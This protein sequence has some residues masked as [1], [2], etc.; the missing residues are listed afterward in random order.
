MAEPAI[1]TVPLV[2]KSSPPNNCSNVVLP[3]PDAPTIAIRSPARTVIEAPRNT[4]SRTPPWMKS[5]ARSTPSSTTLLE[6]GM[7]NGMLLVIS[8]RFRRQQARSSPGGI[9][10]RGASQNEGDPANPHHVREPHVRRQVA[11]EIH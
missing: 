8:Q 6:F 1:P 9:E 4:C 11:H 3:E 10:S 5:F 2:G 7:I